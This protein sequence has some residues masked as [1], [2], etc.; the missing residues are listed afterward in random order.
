MCTAVLSIEPGLPVLLAGVRDELIDRPWEGP[1]R[2]WPSYPELLGGKDLQAGG[3]WLAVLPSA[4][5]AACVLNGIGLLAPAATR[6]SR[7]ELP[8][9]AAAGESIG[10]RGLADYDPFHL[11][12]AEP[13]LAILWSWD[14]SKLTE[15]ELQP[16]LHFVVNSGLASYQPET[17]RTAADWATAG[18]IGSQWRGAP[19]PDGREHEIARTAHFLA[20]F[21]SAIRPE[22][23]PG[24]PVGQAWGSWF[25]LINGDGIGPDDQRALIVRRDLGSGRTWG[26]T[27]ISLVALAPGWLRYDFTARPGDE[28]SWCPVL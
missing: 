14:G 23:R 16:G 6:L 1:G 19:P 26:T 15:H 10:Q 21:S 8:L 20:R 2:H 18:W 27:S 4:R 13:G 5:R 25:P 11:L 3:T 28:S 17:G 12:V 24:Q 7:G 9:L 22:P